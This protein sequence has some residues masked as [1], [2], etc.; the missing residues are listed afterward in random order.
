M[1]KQSDLNIKGNLKKKV[2]ESSHSSIFVVSDYLNKLIVEARKEYI[3]GKTSGPFCAADKLM[4][5]LS[6]SKTDF[7]I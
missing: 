1:K 3:A 5:H 6:T 7:H 2:D 4:K